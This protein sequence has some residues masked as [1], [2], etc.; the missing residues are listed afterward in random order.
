MKD[1]PKSDAAPILPQAN[2][3]DRNKK[4]GRGRSVS[5]SPRGKDKRSST[6]VTPVDTW[7]IGC[8]FHVY[9]KNGRSKG[10]S[11]KFS[12][13]DKRKGSAKKADDLRGD[14][15]SKSPGPRSSSPKPV[16]D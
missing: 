12:H 3:M 13:A 11:C 8:A 2:P 14:S 10:D 6:P 7:K 9:G 1:I 15:R 16:S 5:K 4:K